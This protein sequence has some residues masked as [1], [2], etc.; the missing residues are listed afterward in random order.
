MSVRRRAEHG[1][2]ISTDT[3]KKERNPE[4]FALFFL[5]EV[6]QGRMTRPRA[7]HRVQLVS[8]P[9][10]PP[11]SDGSKCLVRDLCG[12]LSRVEPHVLVDGKTGSQLG[13]QVVEHRVYASPGGFS[14]ALSQNLRVF[15]FLL[16]QSRA[17]LWHFVFAPNRRSSQIARR[18]KQLRRIPTIQTIASPPRSFLSPES[19]LFGD[20][21]VAQSAWTKEQFLKSYRE[22]GLTPP[23][24]E[25]IPPPAPQL[26]VPS[27]S[28]VQQSRRQLD[29]DESTPLFLYPGDLEVSRG[30][31]SALEISR[32]LTPLLPAH[33]M[34]LAY[35]DKTPH[36]AEAA[37]VLKGNADARYVRFV[38]NAPDI[39]ALVSAATAVI[40]PVDD[41]Y[42]KVDLPIVLLEALKLGTPVLVLNAGPLVSL[43]GAIHLADDAREWAQ[44]AARLVEDEA[45]AR[46]TIQGGLDAAS[47]H[48]HPQKIAQAYEGL[49]SELLPQ[50]AGSC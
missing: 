5:L 38:Q 45:F 33:R 39:R 10:V 42:G 25:E 15:A 29:I 11:F 31:D 12:Y 3:K 27:A 34:V 44:V 16:L 26:A 50:M 48:Y 21:A 40:F 17:E 2:T 43:C 7:P 46:L 32:A 36:A 35:R 41:L 20:I 49:Y 24:I 18:L 14:P 8:K 6:L 37:A 28:A 9:V 1:L 13:E 47:V 4:G 23:R 22:G 30:A 19:L